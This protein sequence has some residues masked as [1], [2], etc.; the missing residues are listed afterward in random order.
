VLRLFGDRTNFIGDPPLARRSCNSSSTRPPRTAASTPPGEIASRAIDFAGLTAYHV[1]VPRER[2][3][4]VS[5]KD[6]AS[7][8]IQRIVLEQGHTSMPVYED[9][10]RTSSAT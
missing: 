5:R 10:S 2:V 7:S 1:M 3:V 8:E 9:A 4:A 6:A